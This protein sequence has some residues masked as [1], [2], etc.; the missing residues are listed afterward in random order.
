MAGAVVEGMALALT[1]ALSLIPLADSLFPAPPSDQ[2]TNVQVC[3]GSLGT[4]DGSVPGIHLFDL[5]GET[6]GFTPPSGDVIEQGQQK[7]IQVTHRLANKD[8][9]AE[10]EYISVV[11]GGN[12]AICISWV[13]VTL[14]DGASFSFNGDIGFQCGA[15][16]NYGNTTITADPTNGIYQPRCNWIDGIV[17]N[18]ITTKAMGIHLPSFLANQG[19]IDQYNQNNN[20]M[21]KSDPRFKLYEKL[22]LTDPIPHFVNPVFD[23][24]TL[25]DNSLTAALDS[26]NWATAPVDTSPLKG[27]GNSKRN[28]GNTGNQASKNTNTVKTTAPPQSAK[29]QGVLI[30]S[31]SK[32]HSANQLCGSET[33]WG[34]DLVS[35]HEG[36]FCDM[37]QKTTW[38]LCNKAADSN[39]F[40]QVTNNLR[41]KK[42]TSRQNNGGKTPPVKKYTNVQEW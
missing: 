42:G 29:H 8:A 35:F 16:W 11:Q 24:T 18:G 19:R 37:N 9:A 23:P 27:L 1:L 39:C 5:A 14:E 32:S 28:T 3:A 12:D 34:P 7:T 17:T 21:C 33:S 13:S 41:L 4:E 36:V 6:I 40:D 31:R 25:L 38:P 22:A 10:A 26:K 15:F 20:I 2:I 30:K